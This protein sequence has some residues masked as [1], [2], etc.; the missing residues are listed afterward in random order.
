[1]N[2]A[3]SDWNAGFSPSA[4]SLSHSVIRPELLGL[5]RTVWGE[6]RGEGFRGQLAVA[7]VVLNRARRGGWWGDSIIDVCF[8]P[9]QFSCWN[10]D[11]PNYRLIVGI[12]P[13]NS[14]SLREC[15]AAATMAV[16][17]IAPDPTGGATHY[18]AK[19]WPTPAWAKGKAPTI[20]IGKHLFFKDIS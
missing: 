19:D 4:L 12:D 10:K 8:K 3:S 18:F 15:L 7:H 6:A 17:G 1:M 16:F 2:G 9:H 5:A 14:K 13:N 11:D 20:V